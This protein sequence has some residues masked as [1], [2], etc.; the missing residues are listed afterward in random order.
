MMS[1]RLRYK[2]EG[3]RMNDGSS[4]FSQLYLD[5]VLLTKTRHFSLISENIQRWLSEVNY[6]VGSCFGLG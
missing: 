2:Y 5:L 1:Y 4:V 3:T 6:P